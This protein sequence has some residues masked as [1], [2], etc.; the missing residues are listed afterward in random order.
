MAVLPSALYLFTIPEQPILFSLSFTLYVSSYWFCSRVNNVGEYSTFYL[1]LILL[2][3]FILCSQTKINHFARTGMWVHFKNQRGKLR[4]RMNTETKNK[5][6]AILSFLI[7]I[8]GCFLCALGYAEPAL[9]RF[10]GI[11]FLLLGIAL[12][13]GGIVMFF[14]FATKR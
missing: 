4:L 2:F 11:T 3:S 14:L 6:K 10:F 5:I 1:S 9:G 8:G 13:I 7:A 12:F